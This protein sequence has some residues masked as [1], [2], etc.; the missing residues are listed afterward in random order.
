[1]KYIIER[2]YGL[3]YEWSSREVGARCLN[4]R[5]TLTKSEAYQFSLMVTE[6]KCREEIKDITYIIESA[7]CEI[8]I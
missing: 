6:G 4:H 1:M 8:T 5:A 2:R 7:K 3:R